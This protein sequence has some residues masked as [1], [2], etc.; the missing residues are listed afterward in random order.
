[1]KKSERKICLSSETL[2]HL[3][4]ADLKEAAGDSVVTTTSQLKTCVSLLFA[5]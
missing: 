1:M 4:P 2:R 3:D 5:C